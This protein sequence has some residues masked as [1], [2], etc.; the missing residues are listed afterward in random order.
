MSNIIFPPWNPAITTDDVQYPGSY[1]YLMYLCVGI[2]VTLTFTWYYRTLANIV[3]KP[4][5]QRFAIDETKRRVAKTNTGK[6]LLIEKHRLKYYD[7]N[8]I[9][10]HPF[11][12]PKKGMTWWAYAFTPVVAWGVMVAWLIW[13]WINYS[14]H[15]LGMLS[16]PKDLLGLIITIAYGLQMAIFQSAIVYD[17]YWKYEMA[18]RSAKVGNK[19]GDSEVQEMRHSLYKL[20]AVEDVLQMHGLH[21]TTFKNV[22]IAIYLCNIFLW[23]AMPLALGMLCATWDRPAGMEGYV[24]V[25][26]NVEAGF[27]C[28]TGALISVS[29]W[30]HSIHKVRNGLTYYTDAKWGIGFQPEL[31]GVEEMD[32]YRSR[33]GL[34]SHVLGAWLKGAIPYQHCPTSIMFARIFFSYAFAFCIY[35][36]MLQATC[37]FFVLGILPLSLTAMS[38][39]TTV[40]ITYEVACYFYFYLFIYWVQ[41]TW[42]VTPEQVP[43]NFNLMTLNQSAT[44]SGSLP[45]EEY[46][47]TLSTVFGTAFAFSLV[48]LWKVSHSKLIPAVTEVGESAKKGVGETLEEQAEIFA[49]RVSG[50][51]PAGVVSSVYKTA[52]AA[53]NIPMDTMDFAASAS[54]IPMDELDPEGVRDAIA[55]SD[56]EEG[57]RTSSGED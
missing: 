31:H 55:V 17:I 46:G 21:G 40:F 6:D 39:D 48:S 43:I 53:F 41:G 57:A 35:N 33:V 56:E 37:A 50:A 44:Y 25:I 19:K 14:H 5:Q 38:R 30:V 27:V 23:G 51:M 9:H 28:L 7:E 49:R 34:H 2:T 4:E 45:W 42:F 24:T 8:D 20:T 3:W 22:R 36:D 32:V 10:N 15:S 12:N 16:I 47:T 29:W 13:S 18:K 11:I 52:N 1:I 26:P 54:H